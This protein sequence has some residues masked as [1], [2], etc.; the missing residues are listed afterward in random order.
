MYVSR[1]PQDPN[2]VKNDVSKYNLGGLIVYDADMK[3]LTQQQFKDKMKSF[4][5]SA[6]TPLL[7]GVDQEGGLVSRLTTVDY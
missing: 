7:V 1:T 2:Q 4:Q 6:Q 5:D 3:G